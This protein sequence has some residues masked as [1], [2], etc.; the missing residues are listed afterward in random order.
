MTLDDHLITEEPY[1]RPLDDEIDVFAAAYAARLPIMLKGPT[2]CGK[3]RFIEH[4][5]WRLEKPLV[6][7]ACHEDMTAS[8][9]VGRYLLDS[10]GTVWHDGPLTTAV[11]YGGICYLDEIVEARQD[12]T[13]V[14]HPLTDDRRVLPLE[15]KNELVRAHPD[16]QLVVSYN[17]GY[18]SLL[19]D[20]K[21]STKQRFVAL[22][23]GYPQAEAE[24]S[25]VAHEAQVDRP[26]AD[27]LV[28]IAERSRNLKGHGL[29][30]G[31]STRMLIQAGRL[32]AGGIPL[33][34]A[35]RVALVLPITDD[36]EVRD[37]LSDVVAACA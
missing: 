2:G 35:C 1:Y 21:E 11:R 16:F 3:T 34:Q 5:A 33:T 19:K 25:I 29:D 37:A 27:T 22:D 23:F 12:T 10:D 14:I 6:T 7:V 18:Q 24:A 17:P 15:K 36:P 20:L 8:D 30:E 32:M 9:L 26:V 28:T 13:V 31:A 4:M